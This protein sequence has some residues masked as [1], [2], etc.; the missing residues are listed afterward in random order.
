MLC[1]VQ[2]RRWYPCLFLPNPAGLQPL[3]DHQTF[4]QAAVVCTPQWAL[5]L[6]NGHWQST[7][8]LKEECGYI[9]GQKEE[10]THIHTAPLTQRNWLKYLKNSQDITIR[11]SLPWVPTRRLEDAY[12][13]QSVDILAALPK[14]SVHG[15]RVDANLVMARDA[16]MRTPAS[17]WDRHGKT[18]T[19]IVST[20]CGAVSCRWPL[21]TCFLNARSSGEVSL[22]SSPEKWEDWIQI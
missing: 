20:D 8:G 9:E 18:C 4:A 17:A 7:K 22:P 1:G 15:P 21:S 13:G 12:K 14:S 19:P 5:L 10:K 3:C 11:C 2:L 6:L 16:V